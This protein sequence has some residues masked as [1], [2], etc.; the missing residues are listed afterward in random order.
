[1]SFI[2]YVV[3]PLWETW[4]DL[5]YPDCQHILDILDDNRQW[6]FDQMSLARSDP[7]DNEIENG[8]CGRRSPGGGLESPSSADGSLIV[9]Q[10]LPG[11]PLVDV[12]YVSFRS[13]FDVDA[14]SEDQPDDEGELFRFSQCVILI[15][16][17]IS[18]AAYI[19]PVKTKNR[20][21]HLANVIKYRPS[22]RATD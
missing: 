18:P 22:V 21:R 12:D 5:V 11:G 7:S 9:R 16:L 15:A 8:E 4:V 19:F 1:V 13:R 6:Y 2:D 20:S 3:H 10:T 17:T 14:G